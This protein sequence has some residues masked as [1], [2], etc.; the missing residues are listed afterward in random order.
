[1]YQLGGHHW[2]QFFPPTVSTLLTNQQA[3]GSWPADTHFADGQFG[4]CYTTAL[5][6]L[7][8]GAPNQFLPV[9]QR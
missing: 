4:N 1:M 7:A 2:E 6:V 8:L 3:D 5:V 9:F